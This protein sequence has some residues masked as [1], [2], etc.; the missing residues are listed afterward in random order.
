MAMTRPRRASM[1]DHIGA[2]DRKRRSTVSP[3]RRPAV[4][5]ANT[6]GAVLAIALAVS[7][8][9]SIVTFFVVRTA[10][11]QHTAVDRAQENLA[12]LFRA[13]LEEETDLREFLA[14]GQRPYLGPYESAAAAFDAD[15]RALTDAGG[16]APLQSGDAVLADLRHYHERWTR[17]I[18]Q[19]LMLDPGSPTAVAR[20]TSGKIYS[21][22]MLAD[23]TQL[24]N[25]YAA[26]GLAASAQVQT[27]LV[28]AAISTAALILVFGLAAIVADLYRSRTQMAL[29]R[30]RVVADTLQRA[31]LSG[32]D[33]VPNA[34]IGTAYVSSTTD[35]AVGGDLFDI[36]RIDA[37]R[38]VVLV[39]DV[40]G[41][42]L[43]AA[44][45][46]AQVKYSVRTLAADY[47]DPAEILTRFNHAFVQSARDPASF[48]TVFVGLLDDR[49]W[50]LRYASAGHAPAYVRRASCV[51]QLPVT[52]PVVGLMDDASFSSSTV[53]LA[54]GDT[55]V[56][57][58]DGLTEARDSAGV[59]VDDD[60]VMRWIENGDQD[61]ELLAAELTRRVTRFAGG[62]INDDL[63]L[64]VLRVA[65]KAAA[66]GPV[67]Q[68]PP[69]HAGAGPGV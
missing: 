60:G 67:A 52:G 15:V 24:T 21:D 16:R 42:G 57:A 39:A 31:F 5:G 11:V 55:I 64:L 53:G 27:L 23:F 33:A 68:M 22:R 63:A 36:H 25:L 48:V 17:E 2:R 32:W 6:A 29:E 50:T 26:A 1:N 37:H 47:D 9:G 28:R 41:K 61:P 45:E 13:Q 38:T 30:E 56:L 12:G 49:G 40:S 59:P 14:T 3:F 44:V 58:T 19:P 66:D 35:A 10:F 4:A 43:G 54:A 18:A 8:I 34:K 7:I 69:A 20:Q 51:E 62:R 46:T 65:V